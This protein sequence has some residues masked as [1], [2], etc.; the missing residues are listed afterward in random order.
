TAR[1]K[2]F[3]DRPVIGLGASAALHYAD[4]PRLTGSDCEIPSHADVANAVGAV[5]GQVRVTVEAQVSQPQ[6]GRFRVT[7]GEH[8]R[9]FHVEEEALA[10]AE[11]VIREK[12]AARALEAGAESVEIALSRDVKTATV[13]GDRTFVEAIVTATASG[14][15]R[16]AA[17]AAASGAIDPVRAT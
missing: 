2:V 5:V 4:L 8:V 17:N 1:F 16:V 12:A 11:K 7:A 3:L 14:R 6:K 15:P 9:D 10:F 13:E